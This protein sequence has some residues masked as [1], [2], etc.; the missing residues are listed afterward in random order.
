MT[1]K[2]LKISKLSL[3]LMG[4]IFL[5]TSCNEGVNPDKPDD[6]PSDTNTPVNPDQGGVLEVGNKL[7]NVPSPVEMALLIKE[8]EGSFNEE[9]LHS[10]SSVSSY[11][12]KFQQAINLGVYSADLGYLLGLVQADHGS[13]IVEGLR[14]CNVTTDSAHDQLG[15]DLTGLS[16]D[17]ETLLGLL[18]LPFWIC[19]IESLVE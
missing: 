14:R 4:S 8:T 10:P 19:G 6:P 17:G 7:F 18:A 15:W 1:L 16:W 9:W 3:I 5:I 12:T 13:K 2:L 11:S